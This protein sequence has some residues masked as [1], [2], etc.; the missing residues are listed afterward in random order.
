MCD[1]VCGGNRIETIEVNP[2]KAC[3][4]RLLRLCASATALLVLAACAVNTNTTHDTALEDRARVSSPGL[5]LALS[6]GGLRAGTVSLG[7]IQELH[8]SGYLDEIDMVASVSG[9]GYPVY[10][11]MMRMV[12][13]GESL[14]DL[15]EPGSDYI[16][17]VASTPFFDYSDIGTKL[18]VTGGFT[19]VDWLLKGI[20]G[21]GDVGPPSTAAGLYA[22]NIHDTFF[23]P[24][25]TYRSIKIREAR[26]GFLYSRGFPY[27]IFI[28]SANPGWK[29]PLADH[30]YDLGNLFEISPD[31]IGSESSGYTSTPKLLELWHA[32]SASAA[33]I[34]SPGQANCVSV[35]GGRQCMP[36]QK[37]SGDDPRRTKDR[38]AGSP[39][40]AKTLGIGLGVPVRVNGRRFFLSDGGFIEN[41]AIFPLLKRGC[42]TILSVDSSHDPGHEYDDLAI[43]LDYIA[44]SNG[45]TFNPRPIEILASEGDGWSASRSQ[46]SIQVHVD[47]RPKTIELLKLGIDHESISTYPASVERYA[48]INWSPKNRK[49]DQCLSNYSQTVLSPPR[50]CGTI[51][52]TPFGN[53]SNQACSFPFEKTFRLCYEPEEVLGYI[54][55][56]RFMACQ[57]LKS[58]G[59]ECDLNE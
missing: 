15:L 49:S 27:P 3:R 35:S 45:S 55:L 37:A 42:H 16:D 59:R 20:A 18:I 57:F 17:N 39:D 8:L 12:L 25:F 11:L 19:P 21:F 24:H 5:C 33:A 53:L 41:L 14:D 31:W 9:G 36:G 4:I 48:Q 6:G 58:R 29:P 28:A 26:P 10:G 38:I 7:V 52:G 2:A 22:K 13:N 47:G 56:G 32:I 34:D 23:E 50:R 1:T 54:G 51:A 46:I 40:A 43:L 44:Q 30:N